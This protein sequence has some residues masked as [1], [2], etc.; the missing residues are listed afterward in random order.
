MLRPCSATSQT[1]KT[2]T[3]HVTMAQLPQILTLLCYP[4][5][6][7]NAVPISHRYIRPQQARTLAPT[8]PLQVQPSRCRNGLLNRPTVLLAHIRA[9]WAARL[10]KLQGKREKHI[11]KRLKLRTWRKENSLVVIPRFSRRRIAS[12]LHKSLAAGHGVWL[13]VAEIDCSCFV[14]IFPQRYIA[15]VAT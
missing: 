2:Q 10:P 12:V 11:Y 1:S 5:N 9:H 13:Q 7:A 6:T 14:P 8:P 3:S 4:R 15:S